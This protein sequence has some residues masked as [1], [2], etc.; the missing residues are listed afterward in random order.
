M[1]RLYLDHD[2]PGED[3]KA[4]TKNPRKLMGASYSSQIGDVEIFLKIRERNKKDT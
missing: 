3:H 4:Q 2:E 1:S